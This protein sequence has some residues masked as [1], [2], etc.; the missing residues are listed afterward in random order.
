[1]VVSSM[2]FYVHPEPKGEMIQL[3]ENIFQM[4]WNHQLV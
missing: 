3:D 4:G 2:F 1:M